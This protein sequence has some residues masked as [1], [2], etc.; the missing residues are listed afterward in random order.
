M[1]LPLFV[2]SLAASAV[3]TV[4]A[5][6]QEAA[7]PAEEGR[8][9][10]ALA[11]MLGEIGW[12]RCPADIMG[13][14]LRTACTVQLPELTPALAN[15][16]TITSVSFVEAGERPPQGRIEAHRVEFSGGH[17]M[18]WI[19]GGEQNGRFDILYPVGE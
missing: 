15:L 13:E 11:R 14:A 12:Q 1:R 6:A 16:G 10:A 17:A 19:V 8:Y 5:V 3:T 7:P 18:I 9:G 4:S 2:A